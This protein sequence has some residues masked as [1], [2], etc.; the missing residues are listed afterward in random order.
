MSS[1]A[2]ATASVSPTPTAPLGRKWPSSGAP[3]TADHLGYLE[4]SLPKSVF[5]T[6]P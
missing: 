6:K 2:S 4:P 5:M 1:R 3:E